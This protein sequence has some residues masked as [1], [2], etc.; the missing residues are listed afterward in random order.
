MLETLWFW[1]KAIVALCLLAFVLYMAAQTWLSPKFYLPADVEQALAA[2]AEK[3]TVGTK[4]HY[5]VMAL[6]FFATAA[7]LILNLFVQVAAAYVVVASLIF[8]GSFISLGMQSDATTEA[9][10]IAK[11]WKKEWTPDDP[12]VIK[13]AANIMTASLLGV[14]SCDVMWIFLRI[15]GA[16]FLAIA[17]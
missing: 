1:Y 8:V 14:I 11:A 15:V 5:V 17:P 13:A 12:P 4:L 9:A 6:S 7:L 16:F 2:S 3:P 10:K